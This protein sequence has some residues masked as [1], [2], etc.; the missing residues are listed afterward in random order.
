[1]TRT[2]AR[3]DPYPYFLALGFRQEYLE[4]I[5]DKLAALCHVLFEPFCV[6][7]EYD[8][9]KWR[10]GERVADVLGAERWNFRVAGPASLI[11][12]MRVMHGV[13]HTLRTLDVPIAWSAALSPVAL[14]QRGEMSSLRL[15]HPEVPAR[16]FSGMASHLRME[17][18]ESGCVKV[19]LTSPLRVADN[20][21]EAMGAELAEKVRLRGIDLRGLTVRVRASGYAPQEVFAWDEGA[22]QVRVW[23]E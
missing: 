13:L 22:K 16:G 9:A 7:G 12:L 23:L 14:S 20:L 5:A 4:P 6:Q 2:R 21:E 11:L 17:V 10:L 1:M 3:A 8:V 18:R 19:R 15:P